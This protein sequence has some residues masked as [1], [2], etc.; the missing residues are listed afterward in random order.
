MN[1]KNSTVLADENLSAVLT[2][3]CRVEEN[4]NKTIKRP[5]DRT[6]RRSEGHRGKPGKERGEGAVGEKASEDTKRTS[7]GK[8]EFVEK[9]CLQV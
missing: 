2:S 8:K 6:T 4:K 9:N 7:L 3:F 1:E 5:S